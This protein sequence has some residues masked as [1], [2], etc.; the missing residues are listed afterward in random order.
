MK[1][2]W[3]ACIT[4]DFLYLYVIIN[5]RNH[6]EIKP[7]V[8]EDEKVVKTIGKEETVNVESEKPKIVAVEEAESHKS[9]VAPKERNIDLQLDLEKTDRDQIAAPLV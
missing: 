4:H 8:E 5:Q 3:P 1:A 6:K 9:V 7:Q 2:I